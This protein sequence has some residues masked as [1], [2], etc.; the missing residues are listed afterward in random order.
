MLG[1]KLDTMKRILTEIPDKLKMPYCN[2]GLVE[3]SDSY[4]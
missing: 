2:N 3:K 1:P 4:I